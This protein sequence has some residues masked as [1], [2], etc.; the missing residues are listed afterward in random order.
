MCAERADW[1]SKSRVNILHILRSRGEYN[2]ILRKLLGGGRWRLGGGRCQVEAR[3]K[4]GEA[5]WR[6]V[7]TGSCEYNAN[8]RQVQIDSCEYNENEARQKVV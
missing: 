4:L 8:S 5:R 6:Q 7:Q 1:Y 2:D 3:W